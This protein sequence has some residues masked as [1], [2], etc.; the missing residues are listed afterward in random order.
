MRLRANLLDYLNYKG[1]L[2]VSEIEFINVSNFKRMSFIELQGIEKVETYGLCQ[3]MYIVV[4][5]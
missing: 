4:D 5:S 3:F 2:Q 1:D